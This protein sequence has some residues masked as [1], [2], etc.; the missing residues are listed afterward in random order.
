MIDKKSADWQRAP[1]WV[2]IGLLGF[3]EKKSTIIAVVM[4]FLCGI[5]FYL[6]N[7][8]GSPTSFTAIAWFTAYV[9]V[10]GW[11]ALAANWV[12]KRNLWK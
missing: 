9:S 10:T 6:N 11:F 3:T 12:N 2:S 4:L 5:L 7:G 1:L 8:W